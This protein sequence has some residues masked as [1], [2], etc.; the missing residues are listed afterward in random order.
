M[1]Q[2]KLHP[3]EPL[4]YERRAMHDDGL[5]LQGGTKGVTLKID[6]T[7]A[8]VRQMRDVRFRMKVLG[9]L[10]EFRECGLIQ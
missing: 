8:G 7:E 4:P 1:P 6:V 5:S 3:P 2:R 10:E 9:M